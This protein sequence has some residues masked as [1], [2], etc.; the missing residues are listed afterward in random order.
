MGFSDGPDGGLGIVMSALA[1]VAAALA[2]AIMLSVY[3]RIGHRS[4]Q[5]LVKHGL[6]ASAVLVLLAFVISDMRQAA[7]AYLGLNPAKPAVE[8]EI[9]LPPATL[10]T[11][12]DTQ[13]ELLTDR[14]EK[15]AKVQEALAST[16][17]GRSILLRGTVTLDYRT[18]ERLIV[19]NLPGRAQSMF[20]LRLPASPSHSDQFGPW[21]LAD[22]IVSVNGAP[23][24]TEIHDAFAIRYRVL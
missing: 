19:L 8:F 9:R 11:A 16:P 22:D 17:D 2:V 13:V 18:A 6:A 10:T 15:L 1:G 20:R 24:T 12:A 21:H 4:R 23:V 3:F 7:L 5:D 14:N